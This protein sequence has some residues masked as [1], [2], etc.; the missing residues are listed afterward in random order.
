MKT[1]HKAALIALLTA[2]PIS[3]ASTHGSVD[4]DNLGEI[5]SNLTTTGPQPGFLDGITG[6]FDVVYNVWNDNTRPCDTF[7]G[8]VNYQ[9]NGQGTVLLGQHD[10]MW[11]DISFNSCLLIG[12]DS[13]T[14]DY[15][16]GWARG[17]GTIVLPMSPID[18]CS[19]GNEI[20]ASRGSGDTCSRSVLVMDSADTHT[21]KRFV[22][23]PAGHDELVLEIICTRL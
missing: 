19:P 23:T 2:L 15:T 3:C 22:T 1:F 11:G 9:W 6:E 14:N 13:D 10:G 21:I 7:A 20:S 8:V 5:H 4:S 16:M 18:A 12:F 17:D